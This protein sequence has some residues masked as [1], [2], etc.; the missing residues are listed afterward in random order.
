M[1]KKILYFWPTAIVVCV[2]LYATLAS[3]PVGADELPPIPYLDKLIHAI[4]MGG[5]LSA[6]C[7]DYQRMKK[8]ESIG[9]SRVRNVMSFGFLV[10]VFVIV[11][12]ASIG[13]EYLQDAVDNGRSKEWADFVADCIGAI[14]AALIAPPVIRKVLGIKKD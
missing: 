7:F 4:M 6:I 11:A 1:L 5:L 9:G 8:S 2:I 12:I 13:D 14:V 3:H 10:V